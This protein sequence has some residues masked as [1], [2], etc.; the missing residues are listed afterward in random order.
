MLF[1]IARHGMCKGDLEACCS[2]TPETPGFQR[3]SL[4]ITIRC[5]CPTGTR[6]RIC[7]VSDWILWVSADPIGEGD[8]ANTEQSARRQARS[9]T[10]VDALIAA[11]V[12]EM[13]SVG[14]LGVRLE[15]VAERAGVSLGAIYHHFG[16]KEGL[17]D[18]ARLDQFTRH[19]DRDTAALREALAPI[20]RHAD[21]LRA[22]PRI[23]S[24]F[25][26]SDRRPIRAQ[27]LAN[28]AAALTRSEYG[29]RIAEVQHRVTR[30]LADLVDG[31]KERGALD[32]SADSLAIATFVQ[33]YTLG[34]VVADVD[35]MPVPDDRWTQAVLTA[36]HALLPAPSTN[37]AEAVS[38]VGTNSRGQATARA[39]IDAARRQ[40]ESRSSQDVRIEEILAEVGVS[41]SSLYHYFG[42]REGLLEAAWIDWAQRNA[43]ED[44][45]VIAQV[46]ERATTP[47]EVMDGLIAAVRAAQLP[48]RTERRVQRLTV[49]AAAA[50]RP[51]VRAEIGRLETETNRRY[52]QLL[53]QARDRGLLR[54]TADLSVVPVFVRAFTFGRV[55][56]EL[57]AEPIDIDA[58]NTV[59]SRV[60]GQLLGRDHGPE[61]G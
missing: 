34:Q 35:S 14:E 40:I 36:L 26:A 46:L 51:A 44:V 8:V 15:S 21:L 38:S 7:P 30:E 42:S 37:T 60:L 19:A 12:V 20:S 5:P 59:V 33:A 52:R 43:D 3:P 58:W 10:T 25:H 39:L 22:L 31:L 53:E 54:D 4:S 1:L 49:L 23:L 9:A 45:Q 11:V 18:A 29:A 2:T 17:L 47:D 41:P 16:D 28:L 48:A 24:A 55:S 50:R 56:N 32:V 57:S 6:Q 27:R 13:E 61:A